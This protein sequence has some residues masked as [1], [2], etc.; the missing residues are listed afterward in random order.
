M[1]KNY[2]KSIEKA[3]DICLVKCNLSS[4]K[5]EITQTKSGFI[6][7]YLTIPQ[8]S[9]VSS[10]ERDMIFLSCLENELTSDEILRISVCVLLAPGE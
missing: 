10:K 2:K 4:T 8:F 1:E 5:K 9:N 3:I 6:H 7:I